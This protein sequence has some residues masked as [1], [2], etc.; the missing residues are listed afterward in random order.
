MT[1]EKGEKMNRNYCVTSAIV[2]A[3]VALTHSWRFVLD[4]P[5]QLGEWNVPRAV[6]ALAAIGAGILALWAFK[7]AR[8]GR[9][10]KIVYT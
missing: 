10:A 4:L 1:L 9:S 5:M 6:T 8:V 7:C 2:F 3:V